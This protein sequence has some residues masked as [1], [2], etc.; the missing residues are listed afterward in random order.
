LPATVADGDSWFLSDPVSSQQ[1]FAFGFMANASAVQHGRRLPPPPAS[2]TAPDPAACLA[3]S[4]NIFD[5]PTDVLGMVAFLSETAPSGIPA[6]L[7][8]PTIDLHEV[9]YTFAAKHPESYDPRALAASLEK[10]LHKMTVKMEV[11]EVVTDPATQIEPGA[12]YVPSMILTKQKYLTNGEKDC[13]SCRFALMGN[14]QDPALCGD[15]H[16]ATA[17]DASIVCCMSAFQAHALKEG[18]ASDLQYDSFDVC[19]AFLHVDLVSPVMILTR[20]PFKIDHPLAGK[21]CIVRKSCYGLRQ[22]N[23]AF[24]D[25][26]SATIISAGFVATT[27]PCIYKKVVPVPGRHAQRC[28]IGTHVDDGKAMYNHR[29]LYDHLVSVLEARYGE[30][31]KGPLSGFTGT[32]FHLHPSGAFTRSQDGYILRFLE[33][34]NVKGIALS[35]TPSKSDLFEED[36]ASPPCD[37]ALYKSLIGSL[38]FTLRTR[39]EIQKEVVHLASRSGRPTDADLA[40]VVLVMRYL[41]GTPKLGPTYFTKQ[42]PKLVCFVDCSYGTHV[43]GRCHYGFSLHMGADNA[44][45]YV[46]SKKQTECV[47]T[48]SMEGEYVSLSAASRKVLEFRYFLESIDFPPDEPTLI[49]EDNMSA[50]NLANAPA[51]TRRS[52]HI[53]IRHHFIRDLVAQKLV[54]VQYLSTDSMLADLFTKPFGP[55]KFCLFRG[56]LL[57]ERYL[58]TGLST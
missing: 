21:L 49:Y 50:I 10:E 37:P 39:Y 46:H 43:D 54:Q 47:A 38:I 2:P 18:Y 19:G 31:K 5:L 51:V 25:D 14:R 40:K 15:T 52:R 48:G 55:K 30:L 28:Y 12:V 8:K 24:A 17:D 1:H 11:L 26:F 23:K 33:S 7:R 57:N 22:S 3:R 35:K 16:A 13:V 58:S 45:F 20:I 6:G 36:S 32:S 42:G 41:A 27:D 29:P 9:Q 53:H 44:P 56:Q 4:A 34:V